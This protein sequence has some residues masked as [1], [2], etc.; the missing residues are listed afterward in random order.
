MTDQQG[1]HMVHVN[2]N[3]QSEACQ[4][5]MS[6]STAM[7]TGLIQAGQVCFSCGIKPKRLA[8]EVT[9]GMDIKYKRDS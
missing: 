6:D 4:I 1:Q 9:T 2:H 8:G 7:G 5:Q 3:N